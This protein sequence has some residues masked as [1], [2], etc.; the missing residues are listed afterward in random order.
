MILLA[1]L[2]RFCFVGGA[3]FLL[4]VAQGPEGIHIVLYS[5]L[6]F[7]PPSIT[8]TDTHDMGGTSLHT[9]WI[10]ILWRSDESSKHADIVNCM[11][12]LASEKYI[13]LFFTW[14]ELCFPDF[15]GQY[16]T[17][18][19]HLKT[20]VMVLSS[21]FNSKTVCFVFLCNFFPSGFFHILRRFIKLIGL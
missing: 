2:S 10:Q 18:R 17:N 21:Q 8:A 9:E 5:R 3:N 6:A 13:Y 12:H 15:Y 4:M 7:L 16:V 14:A 19:K 1:D 20:S 11:R